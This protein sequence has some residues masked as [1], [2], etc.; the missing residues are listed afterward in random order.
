MNQSSLAPFEFTADML[1][2]DPDIDAD[3]RAFFDISK[4]LNE[5]IT[6]D[7]N[8]LV[9]ASAVEMLKEYV[10]GHFWRE[11]KAMQKVGYPYIRNHKLLHDKFRRKINAISAAFDSGD[12]AAVWLVTLTHHLPFGAA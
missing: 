7:G 12:A 5:S 8:I 6:T 2:G 4:L 1:I 9:V 10:E 3:H 11:E